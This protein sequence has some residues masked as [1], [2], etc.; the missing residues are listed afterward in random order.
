MENNSNIVSVINGM[1]F[2]YCPEYHGYVCDIIEVVESYNSLKD[3]MIIDYNR[4][5]TGEELIKCSGISTCDRNK[6]GCLKCDN[7]YNDLKNGR[8]VAH[9]NIIGNIV[10]KVSLY[11]DCLDSSFMS[12]DNRRVAYWYV[13]NNDIFGSDNLYDSIYYSL[14]P[15]KDSGICHICKNDNINLYF[16]DE[17]FLCSGCIET[18]KKYTEKLLSYYMWFGDILVGDVAEVI[19]RKYIYFYQYIIDVGTEG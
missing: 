8:T 18:I 4:K 15:K 7:F 1:T 16:S 9:M 11:E 19:L 6:E 12:D 2:T 17:G 14:R 3:T 10:Y 13:V 5:R